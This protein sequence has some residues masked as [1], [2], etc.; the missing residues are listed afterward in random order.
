Y[1]ICPGSE[2]VNVDTTLVVDTSGTA[3]DTQYV[4]DTTITPPKD[5]TVWLS[6]DGIPDFRGIS[7]PLSPDIQFSPRVGKILLEWN[8]LLSEMTPD[9]FT[10]KIDF[11]G[12]RVYLGLVKRRADLLLMASY[13]IE[14][15]AQWYFDPDAT[16]TGPFGNQETGDWVLF[17]VRKKVEIQKLYA[18][19][20][21][22]YDPIINGIDNPLIV[23]DSVF[24]F[25]A[26]DWNQDDLNDTTGIHKIYPDAPFPHTL[27]ISEAFTEDTWYEDTLTGKMIFYEAGELTPDGRH[28]KFFEYRYVFDNLLPSQRYYVS[29]TAFDF[30]SPGSGLPWL[31]TNP[32][33]T[34]IQSMA[35]TAITAS[36][37][38]TLNVIVYPNPYR[39]DG[40]YR[41]TGFEGR[42]REDFPD[43]RVREVHWTNLPPVCDIN[44]YSLDG[45]L[46]RTIEHRK[47]PDDPSAMHDSWDVISRNLLPVVSGIYYWTVE[48]PDGRT[49]IGK[50]VLIM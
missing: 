12:Y 48:T 14:D 17:K 31:E 1:I 3:P 2:V 26:Q 42:G 15:Y 19:G 33:K 7:P 49:Q 47:A 36:P 22:E 16:R 27:D 4:I 41:E 44:V 28:F 6:G 32:S 37:N 23:N 5:D 30:G 50:L 38:K 10:Q 40:R 35:Q 34:A 25:T 24:Y 29:V 11:E 13:D 18:D 8:G 9:F 39:I 43:E 45:D 46:V 20:S 21:V